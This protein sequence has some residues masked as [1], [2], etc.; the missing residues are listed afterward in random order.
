M[1]GQWYLVI[2]NDLDMTHDLNFVDFCGLVM[3]S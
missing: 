2:W 3:D 1:V